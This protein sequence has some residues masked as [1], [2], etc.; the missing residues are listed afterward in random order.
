MYLGKQKSTGGIPSGDFF[1]QKHAMMKYQ[2]RLLLLPYL[3]FFG[4]KDTSGY[5]QFQPNK[6]LTL[7]EG[8]AAYKFFRAAKEHVEMVLCFEFLRD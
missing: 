8:F 2:R 1:P 6:T 3:A 4:D 5:A 7:P